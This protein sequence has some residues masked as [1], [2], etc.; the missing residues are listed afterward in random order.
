MGIPL[1]CLYQHQSSHN[2]GCLNYIKLCKTNLGRKKN[3]GKLSIEQFPEFIM[4][5][6][7][8]KII[9]FPQVEKPEKIHGALKMKCFTSETKLNL[10]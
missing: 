2:W 4:E 10:E 8:Q 5:S 9:E 7:R 6:H 3:S 1:Q